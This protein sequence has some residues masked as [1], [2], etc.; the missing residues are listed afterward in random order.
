MG[1]SRAP[2]AIRKVGTGSGSPSGPVAPGTTATST[3]TACPSR[4][5][6]KASSGAAVPS[7]ESVTSPTGTSAAGSAGSTT[8]T[9]PLTTKV[10]RPGTAAVPR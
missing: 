8:L 1:A 10:V 9:A 6:G 2:V 3:S 7:N 4:R 5:A